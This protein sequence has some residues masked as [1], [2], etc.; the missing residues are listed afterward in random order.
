MGR[1]HATSGAV[2]FLA[3]LPLLHHAGLFLTPLTV[4]VAALAA[5]G[6]A[7]LP[8]LDHPQATVSRSLGPVTVGLARLVAWCTGGH[9]GGTH[10]LLA[11]VALGGGAA[12]V[13]LAG[14]LPRGLACAFLFAVATAAVQL[15]LARPLVHTTI[16]LTGGVGLV[17]L[18]AQHTV[19]AGVL[20][21]AVAVGVAAHLVGDMLTRE[22]VPLLWPIAAR[23]FRIASLSTGGTIEQLLVG[24][25]LA[26]CALVMGWQLYAHAALFSTPR[27]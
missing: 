27:R 16:C 8:D 22:G 7:T 14:A 10:S 19:I 21:W 9:R 15:R 3:V 23:R 5:A 11:V 17:T 1:T 18:S 6:A 26:L 20:P 24:P 25:G 2:A 4:P 12:A 13:D